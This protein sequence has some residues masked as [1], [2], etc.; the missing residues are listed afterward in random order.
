MIAEWEEREKEDLVERGV[1]VEERVVKLGEGP[2][3]ASG[4]RVF[5][6]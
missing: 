5:F 1:G 2:D 4:S 3:E 6:W